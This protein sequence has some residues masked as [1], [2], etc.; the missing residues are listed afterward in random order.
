[1]PD[2]LYVRYMGAARA[3]TTHRADCATCRA[4]ADCATEK[5]LMESLTRLQDAYLNRLKRPGR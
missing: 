3:H 1:M 5:R 4:A 2:D